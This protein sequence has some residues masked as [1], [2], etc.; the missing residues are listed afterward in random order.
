MYG[1]AERIHGTNDCGSKRIFRIVA[2]PLVTA[3]VY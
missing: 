2:W 1:A 3:R